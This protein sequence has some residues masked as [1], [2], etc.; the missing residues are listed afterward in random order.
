MLLRPPTTD[1]PDVFFGSSSQKTPSASNI[2]SR[3]LPATPDHTDGSRR[4]RGQ[5]SSPDQQ[6]QRPTAASKTQRPTNGISPT[7]QANIGKAILIHQIHYHSA[8]VASG[9][10]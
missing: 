3:P 8:S 1:F 5:R 7:V 10:D 9:S 4:S 6:D 2:A